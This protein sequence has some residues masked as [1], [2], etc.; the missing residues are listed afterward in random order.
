V[1]A[2]RIEGDR[3]VQTFG[4]ENTKALVPPIGLG[5]ISITEVA[6]CDLE[7]SQ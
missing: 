7:N 5:T 4:P 1:T 2:V 6:F 3:I